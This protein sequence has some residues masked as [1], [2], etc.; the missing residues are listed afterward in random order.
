MVIFPASILLCFLAGIS[1][2]DS[3]ANSIPST[4]VIVSGAAG[5]TGSLVF[6]KLFERAD[7]TP[8][9]ITRTMKSAKK[10]CKKLKLSK[11][12]L[13]VEADVTDVVAL[14]KAIK[15][16]GAEKYVMCTSAVPKIKIWSLIKVLIFK[17]FRMAA[18][19]EF[20]FLK[21]LDP[22][23]VDW[24][25][26]RNQID[27][28]KKAGIKHFVFLSSMG[29]SQPENFL[30]TIGRVEG[31]ELSGNI[32]LWKRKAEEHLIASG[33]QYTILHPGGLTDKIGGEREIV[34]GVDDELLKEKVRSIPRDDVAEVCVQSMLEDGANNKAIDLIAKEVGQEG[35]TVTKVYIY[36]IY[37]LIYAHECAFIHN[38]NE[39]NTR[40][41]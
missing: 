26:A 41:L 31:N 17:L 14:E 19:P 37:I 5:R 16:S 30:N 3:L 11:D 25:G 39:Y 29:G 33:M 27:A 1:H 6:K 7:F 2:S 28:A 12:A 9:G 32:L 22:Y 8:V 36:E 21:N 35:S 20:Y 4:K 34:S 18:K 40:H 15:E 38:I 10:M 24:L 13:F 23:N